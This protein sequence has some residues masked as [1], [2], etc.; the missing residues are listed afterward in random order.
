MSPDTAQYGHFIQSTSLVLRPTNNMGDASNR[1][2]FHLQIEP[3]WRS[4][5]ELLK[6]MSADLVFRTP[7]VHQLELKADMMLRRM[8]ESYQE[9]YWGTGTTDKSALRL[10]PSDTHD[11]AYKVPRS[12]SFQRARLICDH[13]SGMSDDFAVR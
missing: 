6:E 12:D 1:Y 13:I 10:L 9:Q 4:R 5:Y 11:A 7:Q 3:K 8:F 2:K